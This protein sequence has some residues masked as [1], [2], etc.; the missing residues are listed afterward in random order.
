MGICGCV[1][2]S[3]KEIE[4]VKNIY[5]NPVN[6]KQELFPGH[7]LIPS[8]IT[9]KVLKCICK[10]I[11]KNKD[12]KQYGTG[13]F[14]D[15][16][17]S[18]KYL[19]TNYHVISDKIKNENIE[20]EIY[21]HKTMNLK[22]E[23]RYIKYFQQ[24][25]DIAIIEIEKNDEIYE[26][27]E[28]LDYDR[29]YIKNGYEF[30]KNADVFSIEYPYG[31]E[32]VD[33]SGKIENIEVY[34]FEHTI[35]TDNGSSG[36]PIILLNK[37]INLVKV[38]GIHKETDYLKQVNKGTF[39]GEIFKDSDYNDNF[40]I[41]IKKL[42]KSENNKIYNKKKKEENMN[43]ENNNDILNNEIICIYNEQDFEIS[44][45]NDYTTIVNDWPSTDRE[46]YYEGKKNIN[47]KNIEIYINDKKIE[48]DYRYK[49]DNRENI[50]VKFK[51][52][53]LLTSTCFMFSGC[54]TIKSI[55]L[56]AFNS[57]EINDMNNM[58]A[59]CSSLQSIDL[60]SF[61]TTNVEDMNAMFYAC[62]SLQSVD[63]SSFDTTNVKDMSGMFCGCS[64]LQSLD[65][66][67]FNTTNVQNMLSMF[68]GCTSLKSI[69][70]SS[71]NT[72]N[73]K[74]MKTM[75]FKCSALKS[76]NLSSFNTNN[77]DDMSCM[78]A[79]CSSLQSIDLSSFN[80][81]NVKDM[82]GMFSRC[83]SLQYLDLSS[84][85]TTNVKNMTGMFNGSYSLKSID[86]S[87]FNTTNVEKMNNMFYI[88]SSLQSLDLSSFNTTNVKDMSGMFG[89]CS[90]L[91]S[92][93][94]SSFNTT[95][96]QNMYGMFSSCSSLQSLDLSSFKTT[97]VE[98]M[99][100]LFWGCSALQSID[101]SSFDTTNV[102]NMKNM[103]LGCFSLKK[104]NVIINNT[105]SK[106]LIQL[107]EAS[108]K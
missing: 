84:F 92:I 97:N 5:E 53:K 20:I 31:K 103:F 9:N 93:V 6:K 34:E 36:F 64:S 28:L 67:S 15:L 86:L 95:N 19:F 82:I 13:F 35:P 56:S 38:I 105:G 29:N 70:L 98:N 58:F 47:E 17:N 23:N 74:N 10:I 90:S 107:N 60:S 57:N 52:N 42:N 40:N 12:E 89:Q 49:S 22:F 76:I 7:K 66:S 39:I 1:N 21:N 33:A 46:K 59:E 2:K 11:I 25:I 85:N 69:D 32:A 48:F 14:M 72:T 87:S 101:L 65:L 104:E 26:D 16:N 44:L 106:I 81:T 96:L 30:Y 37:N 102:Q 88:C 71:F 43:K 63:L 75:F 108:L 100:A 94:L 24:P 54:S 83:S 91:Q 79:E 18:K 51:F 61:N 80:T 45:L 62:S 78:F 99:S 55:N 50:K 3:E 41:D 8:E 4:V 73:A 27:I 68:D 77:I